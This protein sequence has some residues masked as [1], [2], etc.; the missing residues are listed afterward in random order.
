[1]THRH[2]TDT[3]RLARHAEAVR[4]R[5]LRRWLTRGLGRLAAALA[6]WRGETELRAM[7]ER[8]LHDLGLDRGG[9]AYAVRHGRERPDC[10]GNG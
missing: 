10:A 7:D 4:Q 6:W 9:I 3:R 2:D 1:M 5:L 8:E